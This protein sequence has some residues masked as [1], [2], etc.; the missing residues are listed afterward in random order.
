MAK[1]FVLLAEGFEEV[2][3]VTLIDYLRRAGITVTTVAVGEDFLVS[4]SHRI[5]VKADILF[6]DLDESEFDGIILP[7]GMPGAENLRK[8]SR[9]ISLIRK[10]QERGAVVSAICAAPIVLAKAGILE[11]KKVTGYPGFEKE[12]TGGDYREETVVS[13]GNIITS[14]GPSMAVWLALHL[15]ERLTS[16][17][18]MEEIKKGLLLG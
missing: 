7:G 13:D 3:A 4:G 2:E 5:P 14:R 17:E 11:G 6:K 9:V 12:L 18:K 1:V 16:R 8:D 15:I 10:M